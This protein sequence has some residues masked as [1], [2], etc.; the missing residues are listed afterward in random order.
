MSEEVPG[1]RVKGYLS[2]SIRKALVDLLILKP[3]DPF[4][5]LARYFQHMSTKSEGLF[6]SF[7]ILTKNFLCLDSVLGDAFMLLS[8]ESLSAIQTKEMLG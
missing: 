7:Q 8:E 5:F 3:N 4:K 2:D 6:L 1:N